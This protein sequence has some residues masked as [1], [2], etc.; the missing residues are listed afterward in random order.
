[1][2][3]CFIAILI[4]FV[5]CCQPPAISLPASPL[6]DQQSSSLDVLEA[7]CLILPIRTT[8]DVPGIG[9][10]TAFVYKEDDKNLY[11]LT[12][13]HVVKTHKSVQVRF[14]VGGSYQSAL[15]AKV[16]GTAYDDEDHTTDLATLVIDKHGLL[17]SPKVIPLS[18]KNAVVGEQILTAGCPAGHWPSACLGKVLKIRLLGKTFNFHPNVIPGRSGSPIIRKGTNEVIGLVIMCNDKI[19]EGTALSLNGMLRLGLIGNEQ[20]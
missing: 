4:L 18:N 9:G 7:V 11:L 14:F 19:G 12:A 2:K 5:G 1:M 6:L 10:G 15:E 8:D 3:R 20:P 17:F 13:G 16:S